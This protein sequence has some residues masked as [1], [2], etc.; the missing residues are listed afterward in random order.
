MNADLAGAFFAGLWSFLSPCVLPLVP[1]YTA[2][3]T[4]LS[5]AAEFQCRRHLALLHALLFVAGFTLI[6]V[7]LGATATAFGRLLHAYREWLERAGGLLIIVF[8]LYT[9]G[10][11]K[12]GFLSREMRFQLGNQP[13]GFL[14]SV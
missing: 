2:Y 13:M 12:I 6:F 11:L 9:L 5:G 1:G 7:A 4:G 8:G 14:G 10:V 3:I